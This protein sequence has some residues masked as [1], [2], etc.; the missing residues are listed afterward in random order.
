MASKT[1][2]NTASELIG[3]NDYRRSWIVQ[4]EDASIDCY[5]KKERDDSL[6]VSST[7]HDHRLAAGNFLSFND[8]QDGKDQVQGRWTIIAASGTPRIS[9]FETESVTR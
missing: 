2:S 4:N 9:I 6:T 7:D 3:K 1:V 8:Q 5:I